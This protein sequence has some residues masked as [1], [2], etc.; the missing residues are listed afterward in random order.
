MS[1]SDPISRLRREADFAVNSGNITIAIL[2]DF[3][4]AFDL[5]WVDGLILKLMQLKISGKLLN[6]IKFF[7]TN[8]KYM[9]KIGDCLSDTFTTENG[10]PQGSAI[11][12]LLFLIMVNDFPPL[13]KFTSDAFF[14]DDCTIWRSGTN[15]EQIV[16]HLQEDLNAISGWCKKWG[17]IINTD[18]TQGIIFTNKQI[19]DTQVKLKINGKC[20]IFSNSVKLLGVIFDHRLT[21]KDH[22]EFLVTKSLTGLNLMRAISGTHWGARKETLLLIYR[23]FILTSIDYCSFAYINCS[24]YLKNKLNTIQYKSLL[25]ASGALKGTSLKALLSECGEIP[26]HL[27]RKKLLLNYLLKIYDNQNNLANSTLTDLNFYQLESKSKSEFRIN[28]NEFLIDTNTK[29]ISY[30][31]E[32]KYCP[33]TDLSM[34]I[35]ISLLNH[36]EFLRNQPNKIEEIINNSILTYTNVIFVDG[37]V[38]NNLKVGAAILAPLL[39]E[40][41]LYKLPRGLS[42]YYAEAYAILQAILFAKSLKLTNFCIVSDCSKVLLDIYHL[43]F[44]TSPH[45]SIIQQIC[46]EISEISQCK[47]IIQWLPGHGNHIHLKKIDHLAKSASNVGMDTTIE[48]TKEEALTRV[49]EWILSRWR[50]EWEKDISTQ[51][52]KEFKLQHTSITFI[53]NR[54][55]EVRI[56]RLRL[57]HARLNGCLKKVNLHP[58]GLCTTCHTTQSCQHFLLFCD[59]TI[60]LRNEIKKTYSAKKPWTFS[61]L[62]NDPQVMNTVAKYLNDNNINL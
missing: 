55:N 29:L 49:E 3:T 16:Y 51:Y 17:F 18:K 43:D 60:S 35:D 4:K 45:P 24:N 1:T 54:K 7:L 40:Y 50:I 28:L 15:L 2:I 56:S 8:R 5:L 12:P 23:S 21:W 19:R 26:L 58:D 27:R 39:D 37:S 59:N 20:I 52:Q 57:L 14:A 53:S 44:Q 30:K 48:V 9:V 34:H 33:G 25:I 38:N 31:S 10:T 41:Y 47:F 13:S 61:D 42:I 11:S 6:W 32:Y 46:K 62:M 36:I 22:I